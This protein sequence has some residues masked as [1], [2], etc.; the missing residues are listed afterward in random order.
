MDERRQAGVDS[1][2]GGEDRVGRLQELRERGESGGDDGLSE[3]EAAR[4][5]QDFVRIRNE[6]TRD[7]LGSGLGLSIV[8]KLASLYGGDVSVQSRPDEGST[9]RVTLRRRQPD[10]PKLEHE[11]QPD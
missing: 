1:R 6:K 2:D 8:R 5:F 3:A 7:A 11:R 9:F 10:P 4:L